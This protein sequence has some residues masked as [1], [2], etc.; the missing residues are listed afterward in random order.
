[1]VCMLMIN[2]ILIGVLLPRASERSPFDGSCCGG[3]YSV[4]DSL[5]PSPTDSEPPPPPRYRVVMLGDAGVGK[6]ALVSQF[7]TSEYMHTYDASLGKSNVFYS[8][9][10]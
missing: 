6:T 8:L 7:M 10:L 9:M 3:G 4:V 1:M 2:L 5:P